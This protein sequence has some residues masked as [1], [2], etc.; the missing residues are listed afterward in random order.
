MVFPKA[1]AASPTS[2]IH[3]ASGAHMT[4]TQARHRNHAWYSGSAAFAS[5]ARLNP[6]EHQTVY[7]RPLPFAF[8][9]AFA[10]A[11]GLGLGASSTMGSAGTA[12]SA[13]AASGL[14]DLRT[15]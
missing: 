11:L 13:M 9:L 2:H 14:T 8:A 7:F 1:D 12:A 10:F 4:C 3:V 6:P 15:S 5:V